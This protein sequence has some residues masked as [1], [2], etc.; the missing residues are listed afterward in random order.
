MSRGDPDTAVQLCVFMET[1]RS[2]LGRWYSWGGDDPAGMDCSGLIV[3]ALKSCGKLTEHEDLT[4]DGLYR[5][6]L[7]RLTQKPR[8]GCLIFR[9]NKNNKAVHVGV[10]RDSAHYYA[11][12]GG[13]S[14]IVT[15]RDARQANAFIKIRPIDKIK[16]PR[17]V[18]PFRE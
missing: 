10:C 15:E 7:P 17:F 4:A 3:E 16:E 9:F 2:Y 18:D 13:G 6:Y 11:A 8:Q 1:I 12:E 5:L 14:K